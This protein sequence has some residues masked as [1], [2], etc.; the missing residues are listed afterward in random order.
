[1][2]GKQEV[3]VASCPAKGEPTGR[4]WRSVEGPAFLLVRFEEDVGK[5]GVM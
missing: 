2:K 4:A 1:M 5:A 3:N